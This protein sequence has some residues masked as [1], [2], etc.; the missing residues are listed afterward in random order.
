V[1]AKRAAV[2][3]LA[4]LLNGMEN[5]LDYQDMLLPIY[6]LLRAIESEESCDPQMRQHAANGLKIL[7]EK[8]RKLIQSSL[9]ENLLQKQIKVLGIKDEVSPQ[10]KNRHI[11]EL[12]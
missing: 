5:L 3:V 11:L 1:P 8:C 9:E 2:L 4:E 7:N 6:R 10:R 12:N